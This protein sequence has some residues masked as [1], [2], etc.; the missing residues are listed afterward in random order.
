ML[1][2]QEY[3][4][5]FLAVTLRHP[6]EDRARSEP[7]DTSNSSLQCPALTRAI[8]T[9]YPQNDRWIKNSYLILS[10][11]KQFMI[12]PKSLFMSALF[13]RVLNDSRADRDSTTS[14]QEINQYT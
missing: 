2:N 8:N 10:I 6:H 11:P 13:S 14:P 1:C 4:G 5:T 12:A 9:L 7:G 3:V